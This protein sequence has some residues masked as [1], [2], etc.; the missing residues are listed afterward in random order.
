LGIM[1]RRPVLVRLFLALL[2]AGQLLL[3]PAAVM[4]DARLA[5]DAHWIGVHV[6]QRT[7]S[8]ERTHPHDCALCQFIAHSLVPGAAPA[9]APLCLARVVARPDDPAI[10]FRES[11]RD[12]PNSR[13]PPLT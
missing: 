6:D 1:T 3:P 12:R 9:D 8:Q 11:A 5:A 10:S 13:A 7:T 4:A 2:A